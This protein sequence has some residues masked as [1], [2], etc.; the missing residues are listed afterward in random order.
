MQLYH[1]NPPVVRWLREPGQD[2]YTCKNDQ[3]PLLSPVFCATASAELRHGFLWSNYSSSVQARLQRSY[4]RWLPPGLAA[5]TRDASSFPDC[6]ARATARLPAHV[7][8]WSN[9]LDRNPL[10]APPHGASG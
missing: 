7:A 8:Q 2:R 6:P 3:T 10:C 5:C 1:Q 9:K 4:A